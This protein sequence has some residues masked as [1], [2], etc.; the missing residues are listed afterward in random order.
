MNGINNYIYKKITLEPVTIL[1]KSSIKDL[2]ITK[3]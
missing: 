2:I 1:K 3:K